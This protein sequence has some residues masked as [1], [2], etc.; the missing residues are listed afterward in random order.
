VIL[1]DSI[2]HD[3]IN[4]ALAMLPVK[5]DSKEA[6]VMM[7]SIG[8]QESEFM[9]RV[10]KLNGGGRG[11]ARSFWQMERGGGVHG[12]LNH[13]ASKQLAREVC[14]KRKVAV[15]SLDVWNAMEFDDVLG[16]AFA[17]LLLYTDPK[18]LPAVTDAEAAWLL[19]ERVWRPGK[20]HPEKWPG[21]HAKARAQVIA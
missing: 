19:Y 11:P 18:R 14:E 4:P 10:Q 2:L 15:T 17:R 16:A 1:L 12:V 8:L 13:D 7:L 5:M 6:R 21:Y 3:A 9:N 20:P